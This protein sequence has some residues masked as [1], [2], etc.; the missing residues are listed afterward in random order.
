MPQELENQ[1]Q[2]DPSLNQGGGVNGA[3]ADLGGSTG[4]QGGSAPSLADGV[5]AGSGGTSVGTGVSD[6]TQPA[7]AQTAA[8]AAQ[9]FRDQLGALGL[10]TSRF[11]DDQAALREI[12]NIYRVLPE[13]RQLAQI[14]QQMQPHLSQFQLW[15][16]QQLA[17]AQAQSQ[18]KPEPWW[19]PPEFDESWLSKLVRDPATGALKVVDGADPTILQ[20]FNAWTEHRNKTV[21]Q[22]ARD[23]I[24]TIKPGLE[25]L[26]RGII[27]PMLQQNQQQYDERQRAER[28]VQ[29]NADWLHEKNQ[30]GSTKYDANGK[31]VLS[32]WGQRYAGYA[33]E[34]AQEYGITGTEKIHAYAMRNVKADFNEAQLAASQR[35][36]GSLQQGQQGKDNFVNG[37]RH[38]PNTGSQYAAGTNGA[39][40]RPAPPKSERELHQLLMANMK[41]AGFQADQQLAT[42]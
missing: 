28:Y 31:K 14:G 16:Q 37:A 15:Q 4:G 12:A 26:V 1:T 34:A 23:P 33:H 30:D 29:E 35:Q 13:V 22:F 27:Q 2:T 11:P 17:A 9:S 42:R 8:Q 36:A 6:G 10:D 25:E 3:P 24:G 21:D 5:G 7:A 32:I 41:A 39:P 20:K 40:V 19:K 18:Q 38:M